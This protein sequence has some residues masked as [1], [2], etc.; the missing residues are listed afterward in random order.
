MGWSLARLAPREPQH[1]SG[2]EW[3]GPLRGTSAPSTSARRVSSTLTSAKHSSATRASLERYAPAVRT[4]AGH[5]SFEQNVAVNLNGAS[6]NGDD[7]P[8][9]RGSALL[10][11]FDFT[12]H[13]AQIAF[14]LPRTPRSGRSR[15]RPFDLGRGCAPSWACDIGRTE[16]HGRQGETWVFH[17]M[18][19]QS[20]LVLDGGSR[21]A[22]SASLIHICAI[23]A[24][25]ARTPSSPHGLRSLEAARSLLPTLTLVV[26][27]RFK[28]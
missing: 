4:S 24:S 16:A 5:A 18:P 19:R 20:P 9:V 21:S 3:G 8:H 22:S 12:M 2:P 14:P 11:C 26:L 1:Q 10:R 27:T 25:T 6:L 13:A 17:T 23:E 15:H 28:E 7:G